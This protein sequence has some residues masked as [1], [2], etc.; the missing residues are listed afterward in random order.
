MAGAASARQYVYLDVDIN[1]HREAFRLAKSFVEANNLTYGFSSKDITELGGSELARIKEL[2]ESNYAWASRGRIELAPA[3]CERL[4]IELYADAAPTAVANFRSL[5]AGDK[6]L[7]KG[8]GLPLCYRK[9]KVFRISPGAFLQAGDFACQNGAGG[10]SIWGGTFK[11]EKGGLA[12]KHDRRGIVSMS[13]RGKNSNGSQFFVLLKPAKHLDGKHVVLGRVV[14]G[15]DVLAAIERIPVA[16]EKPAVDI[17]IVDCGTLTADAAVAAIASA[18]A[19][20][21]AGSCGGAGSA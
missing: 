14:A 21:A 17:I 18:S 15:E 1:G 3:P 20:S 2:Y 6:G 10:E 19:G 4:V 9:S 12:L 8:S 16:D 11:D 5:C 7:A 13:N